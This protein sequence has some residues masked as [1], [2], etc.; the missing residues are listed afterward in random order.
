MNKN[1]IAAAIE[2]QINQG[3]T[4]IA[5]SFLMGVGFMYGIAYFMHLSAEIPPADAFNDGHLARTLAQ[6]TLLYFAVSIPLGRFL[7]KKM[8][9]PNAGITDPYLVVNNIRTGMLVQL[10]I[11]EGAALLGAVSF[12]MGALDGYT[13]VNNL[14]WGTF[15]P[16][17]YMA[18]HIILMLPP[19]NYI[20]KMYEE[21]FPG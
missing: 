7:F 16:L 13:H 17:A 5:L 6:L 9:K 18:F 8:A 15:L 10:A 3:L 1:D 20:L 19:K 14:M 12:L 11:I 2:P 4:I 21:H